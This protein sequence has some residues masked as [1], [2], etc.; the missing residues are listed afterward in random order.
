MT[1]VDAA[2][3]GATAPST[4]GAFTTSQTPPVVTTVVDTTAAD[5]GSGTGDA[6]VYVTATTDGEVTL[7]PTAGAEFNGTSLPDGWTSF[8]WNAGG[9][10][11]VSGGAM[12]VDGARA[13][14]S[15]L[16]GPGAALEFV[17]T[18][19]GDGYQH[20]GFA[21]TLDGRPLGDLLDRQRW[22]ALRP[23]EQRPVRYG[24]ADRRQLAQ[25]SRTATGSS[26][27]RRAW[28]S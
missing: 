13:N 19:G 15:A 17:A 6:G 8:V 20:A 10:V 7:A 4:P 27:T 1:S 25:C 22:G 2:G 11:P 14:T 28:C 26:G 5:F 23:H 18:F 21:D 24:H 3:N 16:Y 12:R 9:G